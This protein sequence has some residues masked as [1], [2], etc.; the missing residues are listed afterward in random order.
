MKALF[1]STH[2][3]CA[4]WLLSFLLTIALPTLRATAFAQGQPAPVQPASPRASA[5]IDLTGYWVAIVTEDWRFRMVT[6]PKGDTA[7]VPLNAEGLRV[8]NAWDPAADTAGDPC[9]PYGAA[10]IMRVPGRVHITWNDEATLRIDT[11]AGTQTRL[12][13]FGEPGTTREAP[14]RQGYSVASWSVIAPPLRGNF[15]GDNRP[16]PPRPPSPNAGGTLKVVTR[17]LLPGYLRRNGVPY[18]D[19]AV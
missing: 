8:A 4:V 7:G 3:V 6:P 2:R 15:P 13:G 1:I 5:P 17:G 9:R 12:L 19:K 10:A 18:S 16:P 11:D 14:T